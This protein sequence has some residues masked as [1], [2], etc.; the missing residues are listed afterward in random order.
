MDSFKYNQRTGLSMFVPEKQT[1]VTVEAL[2]KDEDDKNV[3]GDD[4]EG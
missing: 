3:K 1:E 2:E 4:I